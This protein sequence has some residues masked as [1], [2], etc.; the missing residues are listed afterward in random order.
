M[1]A[2]LNSTTTAKLSSDATKSSLFSVEN[3]ANLA[4]L[5]LNNPPVNRLDTQL[6]RSL[7]AQLEKIE[8]DRTLNGVIFTS[9]FIND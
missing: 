3:E 1:P 9:V 4:I 8:D 2:L 7:T 5:R 6:I